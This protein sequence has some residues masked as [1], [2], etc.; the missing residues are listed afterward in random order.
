MGS[1]SQMES[2]IGN[3]INAVAYNEVKEDIEKFLN[4][5]NLFLFLKKVMY[6]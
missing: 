6:S 4:Y 2:Q 1:D 3:R 5:L